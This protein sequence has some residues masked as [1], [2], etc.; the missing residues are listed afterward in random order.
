MIPQFYR[1]IVVDNSGDTITSTPGGRFSMVLWGIIV[2]PTTGKL[3][4][5]EIASS[6]DDLS[7]AAGRSVIDGAEVMDNAALLATDE[8]DNTTT[9]YINL[10]LQ[11]E[12]THDEGASADGTFDMYLDSGNA[13]DELASDQTGYVDAEANLLRFIGSLTWQP[14]ASDDHVMMSPVFTI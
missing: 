1:I 13:T 7:F 10:Q 11:L 14:L 12:V 2:D 6:P 5:T 4:Y 9:L 3:T 8:I